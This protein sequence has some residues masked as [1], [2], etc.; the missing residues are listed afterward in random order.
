MQRRDR[1]RTGSDLP[2]L[3]LA[4]RQAWQ[5]YLDAVL[6]FDAVL[7]RF[8]NAQ[9]Q[10][11]VIDLRVLDILTKSADGS[12]RMSDLA[13]ALGATRRQISKRIDRLEARGLVRREGDP[14][15]RRGV[16]AFVAEA[17]RDMIDR[18]RI[19]YA[20]GVTTY[21]LGPLS[22]RQVNTV[23]ENCW[24]ICQAV[25]A[26]GRPD[27][28]AAADQNFP[29]APSCY[30]PGIDDAGKRCWHQF[31]E[32]S[33]ALFTAMHERL[34]DAHGLALIDVLLLDRI[35]KSTA[36]AVP[37]SNLGE[38][39]ALT[40]SGVT[41]HITRLE[42]DDLVRRG[43]GQGDRRRVVAGIT[44]PG[45]ARLGP[46]LNCYAKEIRRLYLEPMSHQQAIALG[47]ACRR[48][49]VPLKSGAGHPV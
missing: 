29:E 46:A 28:G 7:N 39:F 3:D 5:H 45:R 34:L 10:L 25:I 31:Q 14:Q 16:V 6:H 30:L 22:A 43:P 36:D 35:A 21:L 33:A 47:D 11:S 8:L 41:Q 42:S 48:I 32:A 44:V 12:A 18:A 2:G 38:A 26:P 20:Q 27:S 49:S 9:H 1:P 23:A 37:M 4:E 17:G 15:D 40:P 19:S 24:R 13:G